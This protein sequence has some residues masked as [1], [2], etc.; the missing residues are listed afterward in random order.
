[1][2]RKLLSIDEVAAVLAVDADEVRRFIDAHQLEA[3][4]LP[5]G[6]TRVRQPDLERFLRARRRTW[7]AIR[8]VQGAGGAA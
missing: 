2:K 8:Y 1:M 6:I 3:I 5:H 4:D 7:R